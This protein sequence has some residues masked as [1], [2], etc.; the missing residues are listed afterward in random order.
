[1]SRLTKTRSQLRLAWASLMNAP[2]FVT[3]V[4]ATLA[5]TL[6]TLFVVLSLVNSYFLKPLDVFDE[7]RMV[8]VEQSLTYDDYDAVGFQSYQSIVHWLKNNQSFEQAF[9]MNADEMVFKSIAGEPKEDA[10]YVGA[11]YFELLHTPFILGQGFKKADTLEHSDDSIVIS[12]KFWRQHF[13]SDPDVLGKTLQT[14]GGVDGSSYTIR[15]VVSGDFSPPYMIKAG[16]VEVWLPT[17]AD[18]RFFHNDDWQS[19]WTNTFRNLKL[20]AVLKPGVTNEQVKT[21]LKAQIDNI[22]S[23]WLNNGGITDVKP[24]VTPYREVELG[25]NDQL[26]LMMLAGAV[27]LLVIAVLNV[28]TLFFS[29]ALAQHKTLALQA[30]LGAKRKT[31]FNSILLQSLILMTISVS[32]A[33]FLS[34]WGIRLFK[35]LAEG[36]LPLVNSLAVDL[37]L[38]LIAVVMCIALAYIFSVITARLVNYK[39]LNSQ[40]QNSGKGGVSQVSG[41]TVR[42]LIGTQMFVAALLVSFSIMIVSKAL[43]TINRPL[44]SDTENLYFAQL[45]QTNNNATLAERYEQIKQ[46]QKV[47]QNSEGIKDVALGQSPVSARQ[48]ANTLTDVAG[49]SSI[50]FPSQWVGSDYFD[51]V[52]TKILAGRTFSEQAI[53]GETNELLVSISVAKWLLPDQEYTNILGKSYKGLEDKMFEIV[54]VTED[55]NHPKYYDESFGRHMWWPAQPWSYMFVIETE[56]GVELTS[57]QVL[58]L[59]R[60][61]NSHLTLWQFRDLQQEYDDLLYMSHLTVA[62]CSTL[63]LFTLL[64]AAIGI[65]GVLSYNLGLRRYEFGIRMALGAKKVRLFKLMSKEAVIPVLV[66]FALAI[67]IVFAGYF[68][69]QEQLISWLIMDV[70]LQ[71]MAWTIT[72]MIAM[73]AC[74]RPLLLLIKAKP[75]AALRND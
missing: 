9:M 57:K 29:R 54:G 44:G 72:L 43:D 23:E 47:L 32:I 46:Y 33:L 19:P 53:R 20:I 63:A 26:S 7:T 13:N 27:G 8:V 64:L 17:S 62:L 25:N 60:K 69:L 3:A 12:E 36:R 4:V 24:V 71:L 5:L 56:Q 48:N 61:A 67:I 16:S 65:F 21:D 40:M 51:L 73:I 31:L 28:S 70:R 59:L 39:T 6:A 58:S 2:G 45:F 75:M 34:I 38:V 74:F 66:G 41:R 37:N 18:R 55:F 1:M 30:V 15:G 52:G 42:I 49:K 14:A 11:E 35:V 68:I 50:F 10:L 22:K